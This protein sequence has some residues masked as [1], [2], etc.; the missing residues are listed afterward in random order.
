MG[1]KRPN[2]GHVTARPPCY[3]LPELSVGAIIQT[4]FCAGV[5]PGRCWAFVRGSRLSHGCPGI[6]SSRRRLRK[7][8]DCLHGTVCF[9]D[10]ATWLEYKLPT[11]TVAGSRLCHDGA[12]TARSLEQTPLL[13][14]ERRSLLASISG[15]ECYR[16]LPPPALRIRLA[17]FVARQ[18]SHH[19]HLHGWAWCSE[20]SWGIHPHLRLR[21]HTLVHCSKHRRTW[22]WVAQF[23]SAVGELCCRAW[24]GRCGFG[25]LPHAVAARNQGAR[26]RAARFVLAGRT[27]TCNGRL[28][29]WARRWRTRLGPARSAAY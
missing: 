12:A 14:V 1:G 16:K 17:G 4:G 3:P 11:G 19:T 28:S 25:L 21:A 24:A 10:Q 20:G 22:C 18:P 29:L 15:T 2:D 26:P 23:G 8:R 7:R 9:G 6:A 13:V 5:H 27:A